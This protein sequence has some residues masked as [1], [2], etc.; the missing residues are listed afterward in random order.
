MNVEK[1]VIQIDKE[2]PD[3][4]GNRLVVKALKPGEQEHL[5]KFSDVVF[6]A[7][8]IK[9]VIRTEE[10][11]GKVVTDADRR[12]LSFLNSEAKLQYEALLRRELKD[13]ANNILE[14][15]R[16]KGK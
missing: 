6:D 1:N 4:K 3:E 12:E 5:V 16:R 10:L 15:S 8:R 14:N 11:F 13:P 7:K 2:V 9:R